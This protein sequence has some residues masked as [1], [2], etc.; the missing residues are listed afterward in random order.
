MS[1]SNRPEQKAVK[2]LYRPAEVEEALGIKRS[3][4]WKL[5][6]A[7]K[8]E[9]VKLGQ[10]TAVPAHSLHAYVASLPKAGA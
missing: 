1:K 7:G 4:F 9:T 3:M 10:A 5:V 8:L 2:L 6:K